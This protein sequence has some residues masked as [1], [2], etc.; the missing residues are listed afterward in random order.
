VVL[1]QAGLFILLPWTLKAKAILGLVLG[2]TY[3][4]TG[5]VALRAAMDERTWMEKSGA[6]EMLKEATRP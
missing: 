4:V 5:G 3:V 6:A 1:F 2:V